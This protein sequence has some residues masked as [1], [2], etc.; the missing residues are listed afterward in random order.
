MLVRLRKKRVVDDGVHPTE[1]IA[2]TA[3]PRCRHTERYGWH[4]AKYRT[5]SKNQN[6]TSIQS[7]RSGIPVGMSGLP[8]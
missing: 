3:D 8:V 4:T 5:N 6:E 2:R 7:V 1:P